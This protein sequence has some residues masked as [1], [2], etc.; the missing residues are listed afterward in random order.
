[1]M[2]IVLSLINTINNINIIMNN[3][4]HS[5][6]SY[7]SQNSSRTVYL[8]SHLVL[9]IILGDDTVIILVLQVKTYDCFVDTVKIHE[10][11]KKYNVYFYAIVFQTILTYLDYLRAV[12]SAQRI[13]TTVMS[14]LTQF[15]ECF[16]IFQSLYFRQQPSVGTAERWREDL[17]L[18]GPQH[19]PPKH[20][21]EASRRRQVEETIENEQ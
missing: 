19:L 8:L 6:R 2:M 20:Q 13:F 4:L 17:L 9:T 14:L 12:T 15:G 18:D 10:S 7:H 3:N 11:G 21:R 16:C 5:L 1:M